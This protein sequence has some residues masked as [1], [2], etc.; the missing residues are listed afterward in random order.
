MSDVILSENEL[1]EYEAIA[2]QRGYKS[3]RDYMRILIEKDAETPE[4]DDDELPDPEE[5]FRVAWGQAM[6]GEF[7]TLEEFRRSME[8][9]DD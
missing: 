5:S 8:E 1:E 2:R 4:V 6:R 9:D 3:L 7:I